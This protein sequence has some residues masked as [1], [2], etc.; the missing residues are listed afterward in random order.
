MKAAILDLDINAPDIRSTNAQATFTTSAGSMSLYMQL[1]DSETDDLLAKAMD[2]TYDRT[3]MVQQLQTG[4]ANRQAARKM[5]EPWAKALREGLD[6]A[7][8]STNTE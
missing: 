3:S 1:F 5:M 2:H 6:H 7:R 8:S 4:P